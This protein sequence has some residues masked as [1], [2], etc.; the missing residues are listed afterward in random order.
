M[1]KNIQ[2]NIAIA[3]CVGIIVGSIITPQT[4]IYTINIYYYL[5]IIGIIFMRML[6]LISL[7]L[8]ISAVISGIIQLG[9]NNLLGFLGKRAVIY[10]FCTSM[11]AAI[12]GLFL[13]EIIAPGINL[14]IDS[15]KIPEFN[16]ATTGILG[17]LEKQNQQ[18]L[19]FTI[20]LKIV[21]VN[22]FQALYNNNLLG[23]I[24]FC[25]LFAYFCNKI[26]DKHTII[27]Q[28]F[29][30]ALFDVFMQYIQWLIRWSPIG[31]F[32]LIATSWANI[33]YAI[34]LALFWFIITVISA[35]LIHLIIILPALLYFYGN[36]N[37]IQHYKN[38][39]PAII[40]AFSTSSSAA[41]LP[42]TL[43][44]TTQNCHVPHEIASFIL[45]IG[46]TVNMDG[47]ALYECIVVLFLLQLYKIK[48]ALFSK[49]LIVIT[50]VLTSIGVAGIPMGS[51][52]AIA[53]ILHN[54]G[55]PISALSLIIVSDRILDM[56]RTV[57]NI[58]SDSCGAVILHNI[59]KKHHL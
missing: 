28:N 47:T 11:F 12:I 2:I 58:F 56:C 21:P 3:I 51:M 36:I 25:L 46:A 26:P 38:M 18:S 59:F 52:V 6:T 10:Y 31:I 41:T 40:T 49:L 53:L 42:V 44:C 24:V 14:S 19:L 32:A 57:I 4:Q 27:L 23:I 8:I 1:Q 9:K 30:I 39:F 43:K 35:Y 29:W 55:L 20:T 37:P 15:M 48:I 34:L 45:P 5:N 33:N 22:I 17:A 16:H 13:V 54:V 50:A 7:P